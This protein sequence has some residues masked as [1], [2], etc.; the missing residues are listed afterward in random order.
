MK[1]KDKRVAFFI[2]MFLFTVAG[3]SYATTGDWN[4]ASIVTIALALIFFLYLAVS[5]FKRV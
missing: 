5:S 1:M 4:R 3:L 2:A